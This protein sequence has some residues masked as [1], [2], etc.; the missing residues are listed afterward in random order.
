VQALRDKVGRVIT[1]LGTGAHLEH[2]GYSPDTITEL[3]WSEQADLGGGFTIHATPA[4]HFS[5]RQFKRNNTLWL[6]FVLQTP[7]KRI[8]LGGDSGYD[9]HF[10]K[11]GHEHGP[12]DLAIL[13]NG[14]YN[15]HWKYIHMMPEEVVQAAA[16]LRATQLLAVHW[17][18]FS[19]A[20]H[21]WDE[22]IKRVSAE[23]AR[24]EQPLLHP[25]IGEALDL[26]HPH[27]TSWWQGR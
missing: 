16:D 13:E 5:G 27:S 24:K 22:P 4:R 8:Y 7:S 12:F 11:I 3:D 21:D 1:G 26:D 23:A 25:M 14:Q 15:A 2:W 20:L 6:S 19:L 18:K 10:Q 17:G 9:S